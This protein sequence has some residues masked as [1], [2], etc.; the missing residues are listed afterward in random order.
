MSK[1]V[2][3]K[4]DLRKALGIVALATEDKSDAIGSHAL[5]KINGESMELY[6]TDKDRMAFSSIFVKEYDSEETSF[7]AD[8]KRISALLSSSEAGIIR[9]EF[10]K[11]EMTLNVYASENKSAYLS[12]PS[13]DPDKFISFEDKISKAQ[14][15]K[16]VDSTVF[17]HAFRFI[18]GFLPSDDKNEKWNRVHINGGVIYGSN[19]SN[20]VGAFESAEFSGLDGHIFRKNILSPIVSMIEKTEIDEIELKSS[21]EA[22]FLVSPDQKQG[23]GFIKATSKSPK[24]PISLDE[25]DTDGF[26]IDREMLLK[27]LNRLAITATGDLG[28]KGEVLGAEFK[29]STLA[30]RPSIETMAC[31]K[32]KDSKDIDFI[33]EYKLVKSLLTLYSASNINIYIDK[34]KCTLWNEAELEVKNDKETKKH[35]FKSVA[36]MSL[37]RAV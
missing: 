3:D 18:Q 30:E 27:K 8:P 4:E 22:L 36:V 7:T 17:T 33:M 10:N 11:E 26:N 19:G 6:S 20:R 37:A 1:F 13:F 23:I 24:F 35:P 16:S 9:F 21:S 29:M 31:A 2:A 34:G 14:K 15:L 32:I 28:I 12:F 5:F 25:P